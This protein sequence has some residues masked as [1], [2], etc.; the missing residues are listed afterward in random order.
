VSSSLFTVV[1]VV[2]TGVLADVPREDTSGGS[3]AW[4]I[5]VPIALAVIVGLAFFLRRRNRK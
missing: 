5:L 3:A 4:L 1:T 2:V